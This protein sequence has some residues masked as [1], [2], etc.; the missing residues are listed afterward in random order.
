MNSPHN[1]NA[2]IHQTPNPLQTPGRSKLSKMLES[3]LKTSCR[4]F[5]DNMSQFDNKY[6]FSSYPKNEDDGEFLSDTGSIFHNLTPVY[7]IHLI[8]Y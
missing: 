8:P 7:C 4:L 3:E 1:P 5:H 2:K 6:V